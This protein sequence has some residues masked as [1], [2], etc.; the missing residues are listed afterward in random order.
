MPKIL[1]SKLTT[2]DCPVEIEGTTADGRVFYFRARRGCW[3]L[4]AG[5]QKTVEELIRAG[6]DPSIE[7]WNGDDPWRGWM[8]EGEAMTHI[9]RCLGDEHPGCTGTDSATDEESKSDA[10]AGAPVSR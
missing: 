4:L 3:C 7:G 8:P 5:P 6:N 9:R 2:G 10:G 1:T